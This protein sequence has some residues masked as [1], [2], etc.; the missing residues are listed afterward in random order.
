LYNQSSPRYEIL[1]PPGGPR[2]KDVTFAD[3]LRD[4]TIR[5]ILRTTRKILRIV[6][7]LVVICGALYYLIEIKPS[8]HTVAAAAPQVTAQSLPA[9]SASPVVSA[10][11]ATQ[12]TAAPPSPAADQISALQRQVAELQAQ[13]RPT[14]TDASPPAAAPPPQADVD[15]VSAK[16]HV[17]ESIHKWW[18]AWGPTGSNGQEMTWGTGCAPWNHSPKCEG[19]NSD[20]EGHVSSPQEVLSG[21]FKPQQHAAAP[22]PEEAQPDPTPQHEPRIEPRR[23]PPRQAAP[24][25]EPPPSRHYTAAHCREGLHLQNGMCVGQVRAWCPRTRDYYYPI[26]REEPIGGDRDEPTT[27]RGGPDDDDE[28]W[29]SGDRDHRM[30]SASQRS[31]YGERQRTWDGAHYVGERSP[32]GCVYNRIGFCLYDHGR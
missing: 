19:H 1:P 20:Y 8:R 4:K 14:Q 25:E 17:T 23:E 5:K 26:V 12:A 32:R 11:V 16:S 21:V 6:A 15:A 7:C 9:P 13:Q 10:A 30:Y 29:G 2:D 28:T 31:T 27:A 22:A 18:H 24:R 3:L